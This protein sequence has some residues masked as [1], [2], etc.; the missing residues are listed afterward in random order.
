VIFGIRRGSHWDED[1]F[2]GGLGNKSA[3]F[4][5]LESIPVDKAFVF[6]G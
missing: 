6:S 1:Q 3:F 2:I 4:G 5:H